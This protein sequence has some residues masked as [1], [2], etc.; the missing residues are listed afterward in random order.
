MTGC[1]FLSVDSWSW[2][3]LLSKRLANSSGEKYNKYL[4]SG[5]SWAAGV[6]ATI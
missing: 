4:I 3:A 6:A 1:G 2:V 5:D